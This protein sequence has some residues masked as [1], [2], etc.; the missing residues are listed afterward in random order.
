MLRSREVEILDAPKVQI[1][2]ARHPFMAKAHIATVLG[3]DTVAEIVDVHWAEKR[4][5]AVTA[6]GRPVERSRWHSVVPRETV[7]L[8]GVPQGP[9]VAFFG[10]IFGA[11]GSAFTAITGALGG[12][13][14]GGIFSGL[15]GKL[16]G[17]GLSIAARYLFNAL[18]APPTPQLARQPEASPTYTIGGARNETRPFGPVPVVLGRHRIAPL[19]AAQ[20]YT[21]NIGDDQYL[22]SVFCWGHGPLAISDIKIGET[23]ISQFEDVA[24]ETRQGFAGDPPLT[25]YPAQVFQE[26]LSIEL[27][28][29]QAN[30]RTSAPDVDEV[31]VDLTAPQGLYRVRS[32]NGE[33][34]A[35]TVVVRL[36]Y[37]PV[38][39][40]A[41][42][43]FVE[44]T[45]TGDDGT[46][47]RRS[48]RLQVP[49]GQYDIRVTRTTPMETFEDDTVFEDVFWT[50]IRGL[51]NETPIKTDVP[52]ALTAIRIRATAQLSGNIETLNG[53]AMSLVTSWNGSAWVPNQPSNN[54]ADL[55]RHVL[56]CSANK[57]PVADSLIDLDKL[58]EW[59]Q[60]CVLNGFTF[61]QVR[62]FSGSVW[63]TLRDIAAAGRAVPTFVD[64][65]WSVAWDADD[66]LVVQH[67]TPANSA[68]FVGQRDFDEDVHAWRVRFINEREGYLQDE[69]V[70]YADGYSAANATKFEGLEFPGVTNPDLIWKL[71]RYH[72]AQLKLRRETYELTTDFEHL[73]CTRGDRVRVTHDVPKW[74]LGYGR[75]KSV[76]GDRIIL[77]GDVTMAT[78]GSYAIRFRKNDGSSLLRHVVTDDSGTT[79]EIVLV[80]GG[81]APEPGDLYMFGV[82]NSE[83]VV[84]RVKAIRPGTDFSARLSLV[85]DAPAIYLADQGAIPPFQTNI[86]EP[87]DLF[88]QPPRNLIVSEIT[89]LSDGA[90]FSGAELSWL[91]P[92]LGSPTAYLVQWWSDTAPDVK[93]L[94]T[95]TDARYTARNLSAGS[96]RFQVKAVY[97]GGTSK[98][99]SADLNVVGPYRVPPDVQNFRAAIAGS[100]IILTW[101]GTSEN[102]VKDYEI[103]YSPAVSGASWPS[104]MVL[105]QGVEAT[106]YTAPYAKG[107]YFIKARSWRHVY[108]TNATGLIARTEP[109]SALNAVEA[110][111]DDPNFDGTY[112]G[113]YYDDFAG[114][115]ILSDATKFFN[116]Q[117][118]FTGGKFFAGIRASP[119]YYVLAES[120]DLGEVFTSRLFA[121]LTV[122]GY[123]LGDRFFDGGQ[124]FSGGS[125]FSAQ[126]D[127]WSATP[128]VRYT[129]DDPAGPATW[130]EWEDLQVGDYTGRAFQFRVQMQSFATSVTPLLTSAKFFVDMPDR[131]VAAEDVQSTDAGITIGFVPPFKRLKALNITGQDLQQGDYHVITAK[132]ESGATITFYNS[133]NSPVNRSF[134]YQAVGYGS[135]NA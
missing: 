70:V 117:Q 14:G 32:S 3:G 116:G 51:R 25:L 59:H 124:F 79:N 122:G 40:P 106:S 86:T 129:N 66:A 16:L 118:F 69:R 67:F 121:Q 104:S 89:L 8:V 1:T 71:G 52:M 27:D 100:S 49:R 24:V 39:S 103:R 107:S 62:D 29:N 115:V 46:A 91:P 111:T 31:I 73:V 68:G 83:S 61:N 80:P 15:A 76:S 13:L 43:T 94:V 11:I 109:I 123:R 9:V 65:K 75:V 5:C 113:T 81:D 56:Q 53:M 48:Y 37:R 135:M 7:E 55:F 74:G 54:P 72:I 99:L 58:A 87:V 77:D 114:G 41:Y 112:I 34:L 28:H 20:P 50:A 125:F 98:W 63:E 44:A 119:G 19:Y 2:V 110:A 101:S 23:A 17:L 131:I 42:A 132:S 64:G 102:L 60:F 93:E 4:P 33:Y 82:V 133:A 57:R 134:D 38:G 95:V 127:Q 120:V 88:S 85:D 130:S 105:V 6:D 36:E 84:L 78:E 97:A 92:S 126:P 45:L 128:Q 21:E 30:V 90:I 22:R 108:S 47:L 35:Y 18:F 12:L 96:Y 10:A 26:D